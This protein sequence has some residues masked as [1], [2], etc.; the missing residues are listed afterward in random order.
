MLYQTSIL[1]DQIFDFS[2]FNQMLG[3]ERMVLSI[4]PDELP[5]AW[6]FYRE[7]I[8]ATLF[9]LERRTGEYLLSMDCLATYE[10][11]RFFPYL[12][13]TL[14][15]YLRDTPYISEI[16]ESAYRTFDEEW[17]EFCI[18]EEIAYLKCLLSAGQKYYIE[19]PLSDLYPYVTESLL[20]EFG[21][22]VHSSTPRIYGY[23][24][25]LLRHGLVLEDAE[26]EELV[27]EEDEMDVPQH[28]SIGV[29]KSW[30][31]DGAETSES[32]SMDD[33]RL[34][35]SIGQAYLKE[36]KQVPGVVLNDIGTV[37]EHG[38]GIEQNIPE[39]VRWYREAMKN[40]DHYYAPTNL[41]DIYRR[42]LLDGRRDAVRALEAY[43]QSEDPY[44]W[45]RIGQALEE[46]W[47]GTADIEKAMVWYR[48]AAAVGHHL[49][50]DR[51]RFATRGGEA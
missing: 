28:E 42:G 7:G 14:N 15:S 17:I 6:G 12:V 39:A 35:L 26:R 30:Q 9:T 13:D 18:G 38:L 21:V 34:L 27:L 5:N 45:Y 24:H 4:S 36:G 10:D 2:R 22:T 19:Q 23:I 40:G 3:D 51:L 32:Y 44:A 11:Y 50:L 1:S 49:A 37:Y 25:Y 33:V 16:G 43:H 47:T 8:S 29:V 48:K 31:T 46:G 20:N 41:G